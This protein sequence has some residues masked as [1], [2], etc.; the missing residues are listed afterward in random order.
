MEAGAV[1]S[2]CVVK[3]EVRR[4]K[5]VQDEDNNFFLRG[6]K[7][8]PSA[9]LI[10]HGL[11]NQTHEETWKLWAFFSIAVKWHSR[12]HVLLRFGICRGMS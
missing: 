7:S 8:T 9:N 6:S 11:E 3:A 10:R 2:N 5:P 4:S 12:S 1:G